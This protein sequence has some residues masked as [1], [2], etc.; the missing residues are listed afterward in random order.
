MLRS[1]KKPLYLYLPLETKITILQEDG[2]G[3]AGEGRGRTGRDV[4]ENLVNNCLSSVTTI[5]IVHLFQRA[6]IWEQGERESGEEFGLVCG[7]CF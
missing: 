2:V 6:G 7:P 3:V 5:G 4:G 1:K